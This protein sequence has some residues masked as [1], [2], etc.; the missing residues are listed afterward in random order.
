[1]K[2]NKVCIFGGLDG[3]NGRKK[4]EDSETWQWFEEEDE[5][6]GGEGGRRRHGSVR[7]V[8]WIYEPIRFIGRISELGSF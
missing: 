5:Q 7:A 1:M 3:V 6:V 4:V 8:A 2:N